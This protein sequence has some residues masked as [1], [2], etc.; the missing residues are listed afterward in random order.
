MKIRL[1]I[2]LIV[3]MAIATVF[4]VAQKHK[5]NNSKKMISFIQAKQ[6]AIDTVIALTN[7]DKDI[8]LWNEKTETKPSGW[9]FVFTTQKY[10][11]TRNPHTLKFGVP[12]VYVSK[13]GEVKIVPTSI[14][15]ENF[16]AA[17]EEEALEKATKNE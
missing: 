3:C 16:I 1:S 7:H 15:L 4:S 13:L 9:Y 2:W 8:V 12:S 6:K 17:T 14:R 5:Q 11:E 10:V